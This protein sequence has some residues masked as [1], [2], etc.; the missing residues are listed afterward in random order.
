MN[1]FFTSKNAI[2][3]FIV[4][5]AMNGFAQVA[6]DFQTK[7]PAANWSDF[8]AWNVHNGTMWVAA[9]PGQIPSSTNSVYVQSGHTIS[10]DNAGA[11]CNYINVNGSITSKIIFLAAG[12]LNVKGNMSL[13]STGH[14]CFG[15]WAPAGKIVFSGTGMQGFTNLSVNSEFVNI[16]VNKVSGTLTT[17]S[18]FRF[19]SFTLTAGNFSV[20]SANEIQGS[21]A[22]ATITING[23]VWT[24]ILS[25]T[26]I[27]SIPVAAPQPVGAII[28][29]SGVMTLATS[30]SSPG[31]M[32][33]TL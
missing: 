19:A 2:V 18:N 17:S 22:A 21:S 25:T 10:V 16:E 8:N 3:P 33:S 4:G 30:N 13:F 9:V 14:N 29:N 32:L 7:T 6:G 5:F 24:Q 31:F 1:K 20:G 11:V 15:A 27:F 26:K 12:I 28:I 23:G